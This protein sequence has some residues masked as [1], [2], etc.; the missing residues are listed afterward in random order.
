MKPAREE[1]AF[2]SFGDWTV[3]PAQRLLE[4]GAE[5]VVLEPKLMDVLTYLAG[6][7]GEVVS[8]EQ[9][10]IDCWHGTFYGDNP[11]HKTIALLRKAVGD[12]AKRPRYIATVRKRGYQVIAVVAFADERKRGSPPTRSWTQGSPF[13]GLLP[14]DTQHAALFYGRARAASELL[15]LLRE[16]RH[17]GCAFVLVTGPSGSGKSSLV[18]AGV[19][20]ALLREAGSGG[21]RA[22][23]SAGFVARPQGMTPLEALAA[24]MTRWEVRG[25]PI[26]L[27]TERKALARILLDDMPN[28]LSRIAHAVR[29]GAET[30]NGDVLLL[31]VESLE[32]LVTAPPITRSDSAALFGALAQL[33]RSGDVAILAVCRNDFY[34]SLM[35]LPE[36]LALK[37]DGGLYDVAMP[38][39]GEIAQMI[40]LPAMAAGLSFERDAVTERQLDDL[41]L[42]TACRRPGALPLL[43]YTLQALYELRKDGN[44]LT[45]AA[46]R[47]LGGLEGALARRAELAFEQLEAGATEAFASVLQRLVAVSS[48]GDEVTACRVRWHDLADHAQQRVVQHLVNAHLLV[49]LLEGDEPCFTVAHEALLRHWPRVVDWVASH[50]A[51]L[52]SRARISEM[53]RRWLTEGR[54]QEHLLPRGLLLAE[55]RTLYRH[56]TPPLR[57]EQRLFVH[58]SLRRARLRTTLLASMYAIIVM[59]AVLSSLAT[60]AARRAE[61]RA[62]QRQVDAENLIDFMLGDLHERLDTLGRLDLLDA[63][64]EQALT[65][66]SH[67]CQAGDP[68]AVLRQARA[69]R[70]IGEIRFTRA[71]LASAQ[72]AFD[73]ADTS[74]HNLLASDPG[75]PAIYAELGKLSFW[76]GQIASSRGHPDEAH[77]AWLAY[78]ADAERRA[79]LEPNVPDAWLELSYADNCLGTFAMRVDR[80]DEAVMRFHQSIAWKQRFLSVRTTDDKIRLELADTMSWLALAEQ[81]RGDLREAL[82]SFKAERQ[83]VI[84]VGATGEKGAPSNSWLYRYALADLHVAK[85]ETDLGL[86]TQAAEDYETA[87]ASFAQLVDAVPDNRNWQRDLAYARLQQGWLAYGMNNP[88]LA[89]RRLL[90][91]EIGLHALLAIDPKIADWHALLALDR[92]YLSVVL[93]QQGDAVKAAALMAG[94]WQDLAAQANAKTTVAGQVLRAMIEITAGETAAERG[95]RAA[96]Q[97]WRDVV[98][99]LGGRAA[100]THDPRV[101]DPY[102]RASLLLGHRKEVGPYLQRLNQSGYHSPMFESYLNPNHSSTHHLRNR[103]LWQQKSM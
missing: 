75:L 57:V 99:T 66:L 39:E 1:T 40:R 8:A 100:S 44:V 64:T 102:I 56:A 29:H 81:Q 52:R 18:Q 33:A 71:D 32:G 78:L 23:A 101:L 47:E 53:A 16:Q 31:V 83:T 62:V 3:R 63:V 50:R 97:Y 65:V 90:E 72:K 79:S 38:T 103:T 69:L 27:D 77:A 28:V 30:S 55:A 34:P 14:F 22:L 43:Q 76:R 82:E 6:S 68:D 41:L 98:D 96:D 74:L 7:A 42:E 20:P 95:D 35:E 5:R 49:S 88:T 89:S 80:L 2:F 59:L 70:E 92:N 37:R 87:T 46:Y 45:F 19:L 15:A 84:A 21:L 54:R 10:L 61:A 73:A 60:V 4:R 85:A 91:A 86:T 25:R 48:D 93:L 36:L 17:D 26:F 24:A 11:V 58:R 67:C 51:R 13:R 94:A 12:D 9:L